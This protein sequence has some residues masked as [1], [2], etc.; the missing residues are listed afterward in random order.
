MAD[1]T[2]PPRP[3]RRP[4]DDIPPD[5]TPDREHRGRDDREG[6]PRPTAATR[7]DHRGRPR[8]FVDA[9][10]IEAAA[11]WEARCWRRIR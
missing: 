4:T 9:E 6:P 10:T 2:S 8:D 11:H 7:I 5:D 3:R 1:P